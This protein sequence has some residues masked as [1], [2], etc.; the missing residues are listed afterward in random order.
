MKLKA[1]ILGIVMVGVYPFIAHWIFPKNQSGSIHAAR[2]QMNYFSELKTLADVLKLVQAKFVEEELAKDKEKLIQGGIE[3][4]LK[5]LDDP[6]SRY[7]PPASFKTMQEET[8]GEFY[9]L[10]ILLVFEIKFS[11]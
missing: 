8:D 6:F 7:M 2:V 10:G 3:G 1:F 11:P 5:K 9:G 4:I